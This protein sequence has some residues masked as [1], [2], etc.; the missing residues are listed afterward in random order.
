MTTRTPSQPFAALPFLG[1]L[2]LG[3]IA[4]CSSE[5]TEPTPAAQSSAVTSPSIAAPLATAPL[6]PAVESAS[7]ASGAAAI[8]V[9]APMSVPAEEPADVAAHTADTAPA[10]AWSPETL[11]TGFDLSALRVAKLAPATAVVPTS[12]GTLVVV[13]GAEQVDLGS[14]VQGQ[15]VEHTFILESKGAGPVVIAGAHNSC[16]C[17]VT[18]LMRVLPDGTRETFAYGMSLNPGERV[19]LRAKVDTDAKKGALISTVTV[20]LDGGAPP[21]SLRMNADVR[22]FLELDPPSYIMIGRMAA[23]ESREGSVAIR[24]TTGEP[25]GLELAA[26]GLPEFVKVDLQ[27]VEP[28]PD[29]RATQWRAGVV[30]G[31]DASEGAHQTWQLRFVSDVPTPGAMANPEGKPRM[32]STATFIVAEE[33]TGLVRASPA[34]VPFGLVRPGQTVTRTVRFESLDPDFQLPSDPQVEIVKRNDTVDA[35]I[36]SCL[37]TTVAVLDEGRVVEVTFTLADVPDSYEGNLGGI[38]RVH[39]GHPSKPVIE[40]HFSALCRP[41]IQAPQVPGGLR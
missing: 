28:G 22:A 31:P 19:E 18:Q 26:V 5:P 1:L 37:T 16:G 17:T 23:N 12:L 10:N 14:L 6:P 34:F 4:A 32:Q 39:V 13:D 29:G 30:V 35:I 7:V 11:D 25:F 33:I 36:A 21:L 24:S 38:V 9:D 40:L 20:Q 15:V 8:A 3:L 41:S 27:P 2:L